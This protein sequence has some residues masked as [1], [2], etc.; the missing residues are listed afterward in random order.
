M[1][2]RKEAM[3]VAEAGSD[4]WKEFQWSLGQGR[5]EVS[6]DTEME[7]ERQKEEKELMNLLQL[8]GFS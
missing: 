8:Q 6:S 4:Q 5:D 7:I 2:T 1:K 3:G